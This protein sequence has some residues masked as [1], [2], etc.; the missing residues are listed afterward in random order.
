MHDQVDLQQLAIDRS[1]PAPSVQTGRGRRVLARYV[2]PGLLVLGFLG[3]NLWA[4]RDLLVSR[5][6]VSVVPVLV[7]HAELQ[8]AG[9]PLFKA[10]GWIEP[11]PTPIRVAALTAG[12]VSE[13]LVVQDQ[14]VEAGE[15]IA[16][17]ID[18]DAELALRAAQANLRIREA[19]VAEA[20]ATLAAA[21]V[22]YDQ[23]VHLEA[24]LAEAKSMLA[25]T[26]TALT[27]APL[28]LEQAQARHRFAEQDLQ[29]KQAAGGAISGRAVDQAKSEFE[30]AQAAVSEIQ[31][32]IES[33]EAEL[34]ALDDRMN[35]LQRRLELKTDEAQA[36]GE[37]EAR[38]A[39]A[40]ARAEQARV[41][42]DEAQLRVDRMVV[43]S[44]VPGRVLQLIA[45][46]GSQIMSSGVR[47]GEH[48]AS[49]VVTLYQ[50]EQLQARVD[51][52]FDD[53]PRVLPDGPVRIECPALASPAQ[54]HVLFLTSYANIQKNTLEVKVA[55]DDPPA[56]LKP[57]MLVDVTFLAAETPSEESSPNE[58][59]RVFVPTELV[60]RGE[61]ASWVW[62]ADLSAGRARRQPIEIRPD[63]TGPMIE[64]VRGLTA[65]SRLIATGREALTD[66]APIEVTG[67]DPRVGVG[68]LRDVPTPSST[69]TPHTEHP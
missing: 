62:V 42:V 29:G 41:A 33:L 20:R 55:I 32:R 52:R 44:P 25:K 46:P 36:V 53:L 17:L 39:A 22:N 57:E 65:A 6:P 43:R 2:L 68:M 58:R 34:V 64:V 16:R 50:P 19:E 9:T 27:T 49:T 67:D 4:A 40:E 35:A 69:E 13:L 24:A 1:E 66:G 15:P 38:L 45:E 30:A 23:P 8:Q 63:S 51:V 28:A 18:D 14:P 56:A 54:G 59:L 48:D 5:K 47:R 3:I 37:A 12:I 21:Q 10:A 11:R 7:S 26:Q 31:Q 61:D 60:V